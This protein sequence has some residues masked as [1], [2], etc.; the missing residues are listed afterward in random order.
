MDE[1]GSRITLLRKK[2]AI[3][4]NQLAKLLGI[5]SSSLSHYEKNR[6]F[7]DYRTI[8]SIATLFQVTTDYLLGRTQI[9][10]PL[11]DDSLVQLELEP[12][13]IQG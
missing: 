4:Q 2:H 10:S 13:E 8:R 3:K 6:R 5:S 12:A 1:I 7:P 9:P 11:N